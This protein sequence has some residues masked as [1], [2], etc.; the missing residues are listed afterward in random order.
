MSSCNILKHS[1]FSH[2]LCIFFFKGVLSIFLIINPFPS[3]SPYINDG[4]TIQPFSQ[5]PDYE[6]L[7]FI[8]VRSL[9]FT[10]L[11]IKHL[12]NQRILILIS[13]CRLFFVVIHGKLSSEVVVSLVLCLKIALIRFL[14]LQELVVIPQKKKKVLSPTAFAA[15]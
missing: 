6:D 3:F 12:Q 5:T 2:P 4:F 14:L 8:R 10:S 15:R 11:F 7:P 13:L 1:Y 9:Y